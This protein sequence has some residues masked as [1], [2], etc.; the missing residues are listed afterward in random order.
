[1]IIRGGRAHELLDLRIPRQRPQRVFVRRRGGI[2]QY[3][4]GRLV[5]V[6]LDEQMP[7]ERSEVTG[8]QIKVARKLALNPKTELLGIRNLEVR[9]GHLQRAEGSRRSRRAARDVREIA[10][11]VGDARHVWRIVQG[12]ESRISLN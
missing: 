12:V 1:M 4:K 10:V 5:H 2:R 11:I 3:G 9:L 7:P 8:L 6:R